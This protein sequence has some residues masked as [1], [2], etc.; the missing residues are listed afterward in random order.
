M[1]KKKTQAVLKSRPR[2]EFHSY[3]REPSVAPFVPKE[4]LS[5]IPYVYHGW[6]NL[7]P[8][9]LLNLATNCGP[10]QRSITQVS[11]FIAG[12]GW[13]FYD[14]EG[15]EIE[16]AQALFQSWLQETTEEEFNA[17]TAYDLAH[18]MGFTWGVRR[19]ADGSIVR[20]D[21]R[22]RFG[23]RAEKTKNGKIQS[24]YWSDDWSL[25]EWN[26]TD[27]RFKPKPIP[28]IDWSDKKK[29][30][31]SIIF[32][33]QYNPRDPVYGR[34]YWLGCKRAAEVWVKVDNFNRTQIDTGFMASIILGT[35]FEGTDDQLDRHEERIEI[36]HT[37]SMA[38]GLLHVNLAPGEEP[39]F[40]HEIT[41]GNQAGELDKTRE[42]SAKVIY[43]TF[44]IPELLM[45]DKAEGLSSQERALAIR[46]QQMQRT[47]VASMQKM[48][49]RVLTR[50]MNMAGINV[51]EAKPQP[52]EVFDPVQ[53]EA[54]IMATQTVDKARELRGEEPHP[55]KKIG[56]LLIVQ[57]EK[58]AADPEQ[59]ER[60][61]DKKMKAAP[62]P[63]Q[64]GNEPIDP[65][66]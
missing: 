35:H 34:I 1:A 44:G 66:P 27:D 25:A 64:Q 49:G 61:L 53:S 59:E 36:A 24:M 48:P 16:E 50:L 32:E 22:S 6:D 13:R 37:G 19:S 57:A 51:W 15:N 2:V 11:E 4:D 18:G 30:A 14:K 52:L 63:G 3:L 10:L 43:E 28:T 31:E 38:K 33:K 54:I 42:D 12:L 29:F 58:L 45:R 60:L 39:P 26:S 7:F 65:L 56:E 8:E 62:A 21:H 23:F 41:R 55:D 46:L 17:Q 40:I 47:L 20:L 9:E 5:T